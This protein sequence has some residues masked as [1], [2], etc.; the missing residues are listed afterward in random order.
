M[1]LIAE[2]LVDVTSHEIRQPVSAIINCS[3]LVRTNL[4]NLVDALRSSGDD[5][6]VPTQA[7]LKQLED[8]LDVSRNPS[9][10]PPR[11]NNERCAGFGLHLP[12]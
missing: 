5:P 8:D 11:S 1:Y 9:L 3:Q 10:R 4:G 7:L 6:F 2:L 12:V